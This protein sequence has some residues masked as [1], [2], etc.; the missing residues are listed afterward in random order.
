[1]D[2]ARLD[3]E[4]LSVLLCNAVLR[5]DDPA[6]GTR[7]EDT[8]RAVQAELSRREIAKQ[9]LHVPVLRCVGY[10]VRWHGWSPDARRRLLDWIIANDL[11]DVQDERAKAECGEPGSTERMRWLYR[12]IR[13]YRR[14]YGNG[15]NMEV[16]RL[17]WPADLDYV[18]AVAKRGSDSADQVAARSP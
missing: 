5:L 12:T 18:A 2:L 1:M 3:V 15:P 8:L 17:R 4:K 16:A 6:L 9:G 13:L 11:P 7:A 10:N 14:R